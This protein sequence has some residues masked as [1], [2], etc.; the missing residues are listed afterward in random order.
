MKATVDP[1]ICKEEGSALRAIYE[2]KKKSLN[3]TQERIARE[4]LGEASQSVV[5]HYMRGSRALTIPTARMFAKFLE[6]D[7]SAFSPRL[8]AIIKDKPWSASDKPPALSIGAARIDTDTRP[9]SPAPAIEVGFYPIRGAA[10]Q[11]GAITDG[12]EPSLE[13]AP[14]TSTEAEPGAFWVTLDSAACIDTRELRG[15]PRGALVLIT[16]CREPIASGRLYLVRCPAGTES[17]GACVLRRIVKEEGSFML[18]AMNQAYPN[19]PMTPEHEIIGLAVDY[20]AK[21]GLCF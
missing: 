6:V 4:G 15:I 9:A 5:S 17:G 21:P 13:W 19:I 2:A 16:P 14:S 3:L 20:K 12:S 1:A 18:H 7:I 11:G 8:D 10:G